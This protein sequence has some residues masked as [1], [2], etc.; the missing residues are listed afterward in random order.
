M[1]GIA[2]ILLSAVTLSQQAMATQTMSTRPCITLA[3]AADVP[4]FG[5]VA[6]HYD[7]LEQDEQNAPLGPLSVFV[8]VVKVLVEN[9]TQLWLQA[10]YFALVF[11]RTSE[12]AKIKL[13][14]SIALGLASATFKSIKLL[15]GLVR[16]ARLKHD[17][18]CL[19]VGL[20][21]F[22][23]LCLALVTWTGVK[24]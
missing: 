2:C 13:L 7:Q 3:C 22:P 20:T 9:C 11:G 24:I 16:M 10:S 14:I 1:G 4:G 12:A 21:V 23:I 19:F 8:V 17:E 5:A 6:A 18:C 15:V